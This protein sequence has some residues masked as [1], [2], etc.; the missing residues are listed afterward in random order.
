MEDNKLPLFTSCTATTYAE[1]FLEFAVDAKKY[2]KTQADAKWLSHTINHIRF[3]LSH[4]D[5]EMAHTLS[6]HIPAIAEQIISSILRHSN[7]DLRAADQKGYVNMVGA[8]IIPVNGAK[9]QKITAAEVKVISFS[10]SRENTKNGYAYTGAVCGVENKFTTLVILM[11]DPNFSKKH[12][13]LRVV[14]V[15]E[16]S[17]TEITCRFGD[18]GQAR[19]LTYHNP[20]I[21][22]FPGTP[23]TLD[24]LA[25]P[26]SPIHTKFYEFNLTKMVKMLVARQVAKNQLLYWMDIFTR[27]IER[28]WDSSS[29]PLPKGFTKT[30]NTAPWLKALDNKV[31]IATKNGHRQHKLQ[32]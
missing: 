31:I 4:Q 30:P 14:G 12:Y 2:V 26:S 29:N 17:T 8:D 13:R 23:I 27:L 10:Q 18:I 6:T 16:Y 20:S 7:D 9:S 11:L 25:T 32:N 24:D 5:G 21:T 3:I 22:N 15:D 1:C 28:S 19:D